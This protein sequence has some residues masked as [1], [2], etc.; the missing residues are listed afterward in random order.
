MKFLDLN[1]GGEDGPEILTVPAAGSDNKLWTASKSESE[2]KK[3]QS[4]TY[5]K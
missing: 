3:I 1:N 4:S 5:L 2:G